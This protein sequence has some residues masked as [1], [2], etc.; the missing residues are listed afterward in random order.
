[1][2]VFFFF[3]VDLHPNFPPSIPVLWNFT[4][5]IQKSTKSARCNSAY[6]VPPAMAWCIVYVFLQIPPSLPPPVNIWA[7]GVSVAASLRLTCPLVRQIPVPPLPV[8]IILGYILWKSYQTAEGNC[9]FFRCYIVYCIVISY[10]VLKKLGCL[11]RK[12]LLDAWTGLASISNTLVT[13]MEDA[14]GVS[15]KP[16]ILT[17]LDFMPPSPGNI[18]RIVFESCTLFT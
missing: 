13:A 16:S 10:T 15:L 11:V 1:M 6:Q 14:M 17:R 4:I 2:C 18:C 8:K 9:Y 5:L 3:F 7:L 12:L